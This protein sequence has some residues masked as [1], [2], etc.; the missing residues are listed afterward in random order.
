MNS[1][2][3]QQIYE[4]FSQAQEL[5]PKSRAQF[6]DEVCQNDPELRSEVESYLE[7]N[8]NLG[9]FIEAPALEVAAKIIADEQ[10]V[11][12]IGLEVGH[13][14]IVSLLGIGGMGE[15][16]LAEDTR[17]KRKVAL[18]LLSTV[19]KKELLA[20]FEQEAHAIS[21]LN[22]P[23]I[24]T[25][26]DVGQEKD[27]EYIATEFIHG[28]TLRQLI[29]S[30]SLNTK[31]SIKITTQI[32]TALAAAHSAGIIHRDIKPENIMVRH[33][34]LVKVLDFGLARFSQENISTLNEKLKTAP[35]MVMGTV[36]YMSPEQARGHS[37]NDKTDVFSLGIVFYEML[38][39]KQP[40]EGES[41][42]DVLAS[43]LKNE[44]QPLD[45]AFP[46]LLRN[47]V[48]RSLN[49][50]SANRPKAEE[51]LNDFKTI[52]LNE[53]FYLNS[54]NQLSKSSYNNHTIVVTALTDKNS[55]RET[56]NSVA[57]HTFDQSTVYKIITGLA[58]VLALTISGFLLY[59]YNLKNSA[60]VILTENDSLLLADF[61]NKTGDSDFDN[62]IFDQSIFTSLRQSPYIKT[63]SYGEIREKLKELDK[64]PTEPI[65]NEIA[66][67]IA[68][69]LDGKA[70]LK[71]S[72][73]TVNTK[74][75]ITFEAVN[76][77]S[78]ESLVKEIAQSESKETIVDAL[79][80]AL[81]AIRVKLGEPQ[82]SVQQFSVP[83]KTA[84]SSSISALKFFAQ[85][86]KA[87][88]EG[89]HDDA[90]VLY[91]RALES[92]P[93]YAIA[94]SS[95]AMIYSDKGQ[96]KT[97]KEY[98]EKGFDL[99]ERLTERDK[100]EIANFYYSYVTGEIDK[101]IENYEPAKQKY[102]HDYTIP[103]N[104]GNSYLEIGDLI[105]SEGN[106]RLAL[107]IFPKLITPR[108]LL[109]TTLIK[110]S[111]FEEAKTILQE[112]TTLGA[113]NAE[114]S[115][116]FFMAVFAL[117]NQVEME[118]QLNI[119]KD[120]D[121]AQYF[122][123]KANTLIFEGKVE[124]YLKIMN[125][126]IDQATKNSPEVAGNYSAQ[127]AV[128]LATLGK[129]LEAKDWSKR[130][131]D[132]NQEQNVL[133]NSA[134]VSAICNEKIEETEQLIHEL[135][136]K[137]PHNKIVN[138]IWL[139]IIRASLQMKTSPEKALV[140]LEANRQYEAITAFWGNYLR[141]KIY[142]KLNSSDLAIKE[143]QKILEN[144]GWSV[145]SP[146]YVLSYL[147]SAYIAQKQNDSDASKKHYSQFNALW[148]NADKN[149]PAIKEFPAK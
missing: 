141:G 43:I 35:G 56:D 97:A 27:W 57:N 9:N 110:Q 52:S 49:K 101:E 134:L 104:L 111:R 58:L 59:S 68:H 76:P 50:E 87:E 88:Y 62:K 2:R 95:I 5:P 130:A 42:M 96:E 89:K 65:T 30:N 143:F 132:F 41:G 54:D 64:P 24:I 112:A 10:S 82:D 140:I 125:Q 74:Y 149:L 32:A 13:Y 16:W 61:E 129:C 78:D 148:K 37:V 22:H 108:L 79:D 72:I 107:K 48:E 102:P 99:R 7:S 91:K 23:N 53:E 8:D 18:K 100:L 136:N 86:S 20:R 39:G 106:F 47:I 63:T 113:E 126:V 17:L 6:L 93:K 109:A 55:R 146:I 51:I 26:F 117:N 45:E 36:T 103:I 34:G 46:P 40:F 90:I 84:V 70:F 21:S 127:A 38:T 137:F 135:E 85:A 71:G 142:L 11:S 94:Y 147:N 25:I 1:E 60:T 3:F 122:L 131:L 83:L 80:K 67:E 31:Q 139:P 44:P 66:R 15:I 145:E 28:K 118:R 92:D 81:T 124:E 73:E 4:I 75:L 14:K 128:N 29:N 133:I 114:T 69:R 115:P 138:Q 105:R 120:V 33:D 119:I 12:K 116:E 144:R 98:L 121:E 123:L 19:H 77:N